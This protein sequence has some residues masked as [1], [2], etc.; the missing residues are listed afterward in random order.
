MGDKGLQEVTRGFRRIEGVWGYKGFKEIKG[1]QGLQE[2]ARGYRRLQ[3]VTMGY[4][5]LQGVTRCNCWYPDQ[6]A[7]PVVMRSMRTGPRHWRA[8][9]HR[10][11]T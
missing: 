10:E 5:G 11:I 1:L 6:R 9:G 4:S 3:R 7:Y 2:V 8:R